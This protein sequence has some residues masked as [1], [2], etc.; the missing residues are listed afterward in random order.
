[1]NDL[2]PV[3]LAAC[4]FGFLCVGLIVV[5]LF[6]LV[7][8]TG[9][10]ILGN[11]GDFGFISQFLNPGESDYTAPSRQRGR[12]QR[13]NFR[14]RA[15]MVD[16]DQAVASKRQQNPPAAIK[17]DSHSLQRPG[18][19]PNAGF[20]PQGSSRPQPPASTTPPSIDLGNRDYP[21]KYSSPRLGARRRR[22]RNQD[23][24]FGGMLD[25]DGDGDLDF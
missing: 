17:G 4:G 20:Q 9:S 25:E 23:E 24:V 1:M 3:I 7:R 16:F 14:E 22:D 10:S 19:A 2:M 13:P 8:F 18:A 6:V 21:D 5:G 12:G 15:Q 11:M